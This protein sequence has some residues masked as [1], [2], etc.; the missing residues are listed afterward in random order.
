MKILVDINGVLKGSN[1]DPIA[2]GIVLIGTLTAFNQIFLMSS[3]PRQQ[4]EQWLDI[5]KIVDY[6]GIID[7]SYRL[8]GEEL[9]ERQ[10]MV[11]RSLGRVDLLITNNPKLWAFAF[12]QGIP[13]IMFGV[14]SYTRPEFRPDAPK[15]LRAWNDIEQAIERQNIARTQDA[16][17]T[18]S[19]GV[20]FE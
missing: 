9:A 5:N 12:E 3:D 20:S 19:E 7:S 11:A 10:V 17:L 14:P 15:K 6:D 1:E 4:L 2:T 18:R 13:S 16:R 8:E